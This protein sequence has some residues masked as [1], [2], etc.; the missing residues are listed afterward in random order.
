M[1]KNNYSPIVLKRKTK[2]RKT[3]LQYGALKKS[4]IQ[5]AHGVPRC[6]ENKGNAQRHAEMRDCRL[7]VR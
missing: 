4:L 2:T 3:H 1:K 5:G 7:M 6:G